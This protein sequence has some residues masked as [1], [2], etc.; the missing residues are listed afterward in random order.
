MRQAIALRKS[1]ALSRCLNVSKRSFA[2][3]RRTMPALLSGHAIKM[4]T[5]ISTAATL[6]KATEWTLLSFLSRS[7]QVHLATFRWQTLDSQPHFQ[8]SFVQSRCMGEM[9]EANQNRDPSD[10]RNLPRSLSKCGQIV[11]SRASHCVQIAAEQSDI[12]F[13]RRRCI[14][15][16][17]AKPDYTPTMSLNRGL[18]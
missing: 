7:L 12:A 14:F 9:V 1:D 4:T 10:R 13:A 6:K 5:P 15:M 3:R 18:F 11:H 2:H 17:G 16:T 8:T